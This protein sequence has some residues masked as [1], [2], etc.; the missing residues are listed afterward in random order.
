MPAGPPR[1]R[2]LH[3]RRQPRI[4]AAREGLLAEPHVGLA[5][6]DDPQVR[7]VDLADVHPGVGPPGE[8]VP[9][10]PAVEVQRFEFRVGVADDLGQEAVGADVVVERGPELLGGP[11]VGLG[12]CSVPVAGRVGEP[13]QLSVRPLKLAA[14]RRCLLGLQVLRGE[15][16]D[17]RVD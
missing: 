11:Q 13:V 10:E 7:Q 14:R 4:P 16:H 2:R 6:L 12:Q 8:P 9:Q 15:R 1:A 5:G 3:R 17:L